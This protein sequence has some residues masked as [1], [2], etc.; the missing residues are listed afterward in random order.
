MKNIKIISTLG[1][2]TLKKK[3]L[4]SIKK[5]IDIFRLNMS[6]LTL[7]E[8][9]KNLKF[10]K[11]HKIKNICLDTEG[12]QVRTLRI[13]KKY[14]KKNTRVELSCMHKTKNRVIQLYP[15]FSF[16]KIKAKTKISIGFNGLKLETIR[17]RKDKLYCKVIAPGYL[18]SNKGVHIHSELT[19]DPLTKKDI[20]AI[21]IANKFSVKIFALSFANSENDVG[22]IK[23]M[24]PK[25]FIFIIYIKI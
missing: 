1:P 14:F 2:S 16:K 11:D 8:L 12:A 22:L 25:W 6:H 20:K 18:E 4:S 13:K 23:K 24:I 15:I 10:L 9:V 7:E 19:L 21:V 17:A 5:D 3:I